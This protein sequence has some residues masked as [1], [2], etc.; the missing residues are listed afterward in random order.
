MWWPARLIRDNLIGTLYRI[1][2]EQCKSVATG[3]SIA[4]GVLLR[5]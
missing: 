3:P 2:V 4:T 1:A 5:L